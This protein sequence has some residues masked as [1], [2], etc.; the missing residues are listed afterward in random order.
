MYW[1]DSAFERRCILWSAERRRLPCG[2]G[3]A[4]GAQHS[5]LSLWPR[6][7]E[8]ITRSWGVVRTADGDEIKRAYRKLAMKYHPDRADGD[9]AA[10]GSEV[11]GVFRG[12]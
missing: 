7:S 1:A 11:Q 12:L 4:L 5:G 2:G 9:K 3:S 10:A 6:P 8:T